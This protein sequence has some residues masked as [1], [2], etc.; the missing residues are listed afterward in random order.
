MNSLPQVVFLCPT[1][2]F[3]SPRNIRTK[4]IAQYLKENYR[5]SIVCFNSNV[6]DITVTEEDNISIV[7]LP[8]TWMSRFITNRQFGH[9]QPAGILRVLCRSIS[10]VINRFWLFPDPWMAEK[11]RMLQAFSRIKL[12]PD[13]LVASVMPFSM[14]LVAIEYRQSLSKDANLKL[15]F[16]IGDPLS[17]NIIPI[18]KRTRKALMK[19]EQR[20]LNE[21]NHTVLTNENTANHY[22]DTFGVSRDRVSVIPQGANV[23]SDTSVK[24]SL[25]KKSQYSLRY[26]G[27][28]IESVRDPRPL[29]TTLAAPNA[30]FK[31]TV[32]GT[33]DP[34]FINGN[35][36]VDFCGWLSH[37]QMTGFYQQADCLLF[38]DNDKSL[39]TS[40]KIYELL[41]VR[42]PILF[43]YSDKNSTVK[44]SCDHFNHILFVLN[45]EHAIQAALQEV[46]GWLE[47]LSARFSSDGG[48]A[49]YDVQQYSWESR[50]A[51]FNLA[52]QSVLSE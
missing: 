29:I 14:A 28:F 47:Q 31:L 46:E 4:H 3:A 10:F 8:Y 35:S 19:L 30:I 20:I 1:Y 43:I 26:A 38:I 49:H 24:Y 6:E 52:I 39:Q 25:S 37:S 7:R 51:Q 42:R 23:A 33:I 12:V 32:C 22:R 48:M 27:T 13:V 45:E 15:V 21:S 2:D 50:A 11:K 40:G 9:F 36:H 41:A 17:H 5:I 18:K 16:D 44:A 34:Q